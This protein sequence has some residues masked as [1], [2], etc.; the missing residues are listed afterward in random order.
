MFKTLS[1]LIAGANARAED[2]VRDAFAIELIDQKIRDADAHLRAAKA[3]LASLIQRERS[4]ARQLDALHTRAADL[5]ARATSALAAGETALATEAAEAIAVLEN[6]QAIRTDTLSRLE[7]QVL[8]LRTSIDAG[9]RRIIDLKQG[10]IQ[11]RAMRRE[12]DIQARLTTNLGGISAAQ[13]AEELIARVL[14]RDDPF[15]QAQ[16][17]ADIDADLSKTNIA[18]RLSDRGF[19]PTTRITAAQVLA[20]LTPPQTQG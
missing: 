2:R 12:Q 17:L 10:A 7:A 13:E 6:E 14:G 9:H 3:T 20:R 5:I 15:E 11:A 18:D 1:T 19:G 16:I 4:E 8:R